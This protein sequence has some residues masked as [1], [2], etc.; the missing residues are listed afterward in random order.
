MMK[1]KVKNEKRSICQWIYSVSLTPQEILKALK[2]Y[3]SQN[4]KITDIPDYDAPG[5]PHLSINLTGDVSKENYKPKLVFSW[6]P[7]YLNH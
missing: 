5:K 7:G 6:S 3:Y 1:L 4:S 2:N